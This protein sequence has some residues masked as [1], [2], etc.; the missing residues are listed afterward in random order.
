MARDLAK[1]LRAITVLKGAGTV[2]GDDTG[3]LHI[4]TTGNAALATAGTGDVLA[5]L[6]AALM[7]QGIA[8]MTA[9]RESVRI[10]GEA[11]ERLT[12]ALGGPVGLSASELIPEIRVLLNRAVG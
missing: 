9:A 3:A 7:A 6:I 4:N 1:Q 12:A 11:A 10:H 2:I 5:G 8:P